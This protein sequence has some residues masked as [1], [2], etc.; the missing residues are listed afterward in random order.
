MNF[1]NLAAQRVKS[2]RLLTPFLFFLFATSF[3]LLGK[4]VAAQIPQSPVDCDD[5]TDPEFHSLRPYQASP[6]N[7]GISGAAFCGNGIA[8]SEQVA[9]TQSSNPGTDPNCTLVDSRNRKYK[10]TYNIHKERTIIID[11]SSAEFPILGNTELVKNSN[12]SNNEIGEAE[13]VNEYVSWYLNGVANRAEEGES[14]PQ[15]DFSGPLNKLLP[16][17][18]QHKQRIETIEKA[19]GKDVNEDDVAQNQERHNQIVVCAESALGPIGDF[20]RIGKKEPIECYEGD[21]SDAQGIVYRLEKWDGNLSPWNDAVDILV[22]VFTALLPSVPRETIRESVANHWNKR[23]PPLP[24]EKQY[25]ENPKLYLKHYNEWRGKTCVLIP[26]VNLLVCL[27]NYL[28]PNEYADLFPYVPYSSTEDREGSVQISEFGIRATSPDAQIKNQSFTNQSPAELFFAHTEEISDLA[29]LLQSTYAPAGESSGSAPSVG[30]APNDCSLVNIRS[31]PGDQLFPGEISGDLAYDIEFSCDFEIGPGGWRPQEC[32]K[33]VLISLGTITKTPMVDEVW[34]KLVAGPQGIFKRIYPKVGEGG[35][36]ECL[37]D[38]PAAT[39][40]DYQGGG[41]TL[42]TNPAERVGQSPELYFPH[43]GGI[44]EYFLKGIQTALRPKGFGEQVIVG[45]NCQNLTCSSGKIGSLPDLPSVSEG[46]CR[47]SN[48]RQLGAANLSELPTFVK[49]VEAAADAFKVPPGLILGVMYGEGVFNPGRYEWTEENVRNWSMGCTTM[50]NCTPGVWPSQVTHF[51][52]PYWEAVKDAVKVVDPSREPNPC[53][54]MDNVFAV[55]KTLKTNTGA[56]DFAGKT[57]FGIPLKTG[58]VN[59]NSCS[60][61]TSDVETAIKMWETGVQYLCVT[62]EGGCAVGGLNAICP[63]G[64]TCE[65]INRRYSNPSHNAC[66][67]DVYQ[68]YK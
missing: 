50:P 2:F 16:L 66:V 40:V 42:V 64:D 23:V 9:T 10:C 63:T 13:K 1:V 65:T 57:C 38:I 34:S 18:I 26:I 30:I 52:E 39:K 7:E 54:L 45:Q 29:S 46:S 3:L 58:G 25:E 68:K 62:K 32:K 11:L 43:V 55:A 8:I 33:D 21:N 6:C 28:V 41:V 60:W 20:L 36:L 56:P 15:V 17:T 12:N 27:E 24:W 47:L 4:T 22:N 35:A 5:T 14:G 59:P 37:A 49:I 19:L 44:S 51:Y 53:N 31:N 48:S 67:W 61:G